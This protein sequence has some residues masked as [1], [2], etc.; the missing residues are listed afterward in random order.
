[1]RGLEDL[2]KY[3]LA[4]VPI[5][6]VEIDFYPQ[7]KAVTNRIGGKVVAVLAIEKKDSPVRVDLRMVRGLKV[8][9]FPQDWQRGWSFAEVAIEH[10]PSELTL[11]SPDVVMHWNAEKGLRTWE[12]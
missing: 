12:L 6:V 4:G 9:M 7:A 10:G 11:C 1:M 5:D 8:A 2:A 3:R